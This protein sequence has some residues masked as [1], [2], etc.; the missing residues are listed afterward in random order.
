MQAYIR[1]KLRRGNKFDFREE[2]PSG[3]RLFS[4]KKQID[5]RIRKRINEKSRHGHALVSDLIRHP[6]RAEEIKEMLHI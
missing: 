2:F 6:D 3:I 1:A 4:A 5:F